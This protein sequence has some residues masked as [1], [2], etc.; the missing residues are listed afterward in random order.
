VDLAHT[1]E[2]QAVAEGIESTEAA[3]MLQRFGCDIAQ[4]WEFAK[5]LPATQF[6]NWFKEMARTQVSAES[7]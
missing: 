1:F 5:A 2:M 3:D 6:V 7:R 4:G